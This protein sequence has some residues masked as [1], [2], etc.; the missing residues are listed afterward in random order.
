M[1]WLEGSL[2]CRLV[3]HTSPWSW[4]CGV[5]IEQ[6]RKEQEIEHPP[7]TSHLWD[8]TGDPEG[9]ACQ[10]GIWVIVTP[11]WGLSPSPGHSRAQLWLLP[12][13]VSVWGLGENRDLRLQAAVY[14]WHTYTCMHAGTCI[15]Q[16][17]T[18]VHIHVPMSM[19]VTWMHAHVHTQMSLDICVNTC[20]LPYLMKSKTPWIVRSSVILWTWGRGKILRIKFWYNAFLGFLGGLDGKESA[21]NA[22]DL[23]SIPGLGRS[24]GEGHGNL[25]QYY[26]LE[27]STDRGAWWATVH[28]VAKPDTTEQLTQHTD[29]ML[30]YQHLYLYLLEEL[31]S[32]I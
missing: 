28:G 22:E 26:C 24:P 32:L 4:T 17:F 11:L 5:G 14:H 30:S 9:R 6:L 13:W 23:G 19:C 15:V 29:T 27:I 1:C 18:H 10:H 20:L 16:V 31:F 7:P 3:V 12:E 21:C 25:L 8:L 2:K